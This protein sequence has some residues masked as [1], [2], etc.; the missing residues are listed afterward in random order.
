MDLVQPQD[1]LRAVPSARVREGKLNPEIFHAYDIRGVYGT[2]F[3]D[4]FARELA[5]KIVTHYG[6]RTVL[7]ARDG[8]P[9]SEGLERLVTNGVTQAGADVVSIGLSTTPLFY[10][11]VIAAQADLGIMITASHNPSQ[12]NGFKVIKE[13]GTL[14]GGP[15]LKRV[16]AEEY[17]VTNGSGTITQLSTSE[18][19]L[20]KVFEMVGPEP[21]GIALSVNAPELMQGHMQALAQQYQLTFDRQASLH[22]HVDPDADRVSFHE[23]GVKIPADFIC[24][25]LTDALGATTVVH[26]LRFSRSVLEHWK[27]KGVKAI[28]SRV[29]RLNIAMAMREHDAQVGGEISGHFYF[30]P[31]HYLESPEV[32]LLLVLRAMQATGQSL[33]DLSNVY[34]KYAKSEEVTIEGKERWFELRERLRKAFPDGTITE[35]DG[36][37]VEY[38]EPDGS[39]SWWCNLRPSNTEPVM[40]LIV[41]AKSKDL[42]DEKVSELRYLLS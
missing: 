21:M 41:E 31:F 36:I 12:Y 20:A 42:L 13:D 14:V 6:A 7:I 11:S 24:A 8:R 28:S 22:I 23:G 39:L 18:Q 16:H 29:G 10:F 26:D 2:D 40:R 19:Y 4:Q 9:S 17:L 1:G 15:P 32:A 38:T 35:S 3:D 30:K 33:T 34:R 25:L 37:I 27:D 5:N